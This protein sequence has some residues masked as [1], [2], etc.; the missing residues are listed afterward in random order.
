MTK[1]RPPQEIPCPDAF[2]RWLIRAL[3]Q[4]GLRP[5]A[6]S[7]A[8]GPSVNTVGQFLRNPEKDMTL[9]KAAL[10]E[11][12]VRDAAKKEGITLP[13]IITRLVAMPGVGK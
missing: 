6:V 3:S 4:L 7:S 5:A 1:P 11:R 10:I 12:H 2:R 8:I 13:P 9:S